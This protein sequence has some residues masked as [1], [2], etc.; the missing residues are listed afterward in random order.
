[1]V[2]PMNPTNDGGEENMNATPR[3]RSFPFAHSGLLAFALLTGLAPSAAQSADW[4]ITPSVTLGLG[5][6]DNINLATPGNEVSDRVLEI[7]P[8]IDA[9]YD[10][11]RFETDITYRLQALDYR[12]DSSLDETYHQLAGRATAWLVPDTFSLDALL[13]VRQQ[14]IDTTA[15]I[16]TSNIAGSGNLTDENTAYL[17]PRWTFRVSERAQADLRYATSKIDYD[18]A[19]LTDSTQEAIAA[20]VESTSQPSHLY[21]AAK[22]RQ[23]RIDFDS[24]EEI[25]FEQGTLE[26]GIPV[27]ARSRFIVLVGD[28]KNTFRLSDGSDAPDDSYWMV[29]LRSQHAERYQ[30]EILA[31]ERV[32]GNTAS[33]R[34][35]QQGRRWTTEALYTEDYITYAE[36]RLEI[37]PQAPE[38]ILPGPGLGAV[39]PEVYLRERAQ[40]GATLERPKTTFRVSVYDEDRS[41]QTSN[42]RESLKGME[43]SIIWR[44]GS[45]TTFTLS[46]GRQENQ[47]AGTNATDELKRVNLGVERRFGRRVQGNFYLRRADQSSDVSAREYVENSATL[48]A[49]LTF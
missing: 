8:G 25:R 44:A 7:T 33:L 19:S 11:P 14:V 12:D 2:R 24:Q 26:V 39:A 47:L 45:L 35:M 4:R 21:W 41:Y 28:E 31:G 9:S 20:V 13:S 18:D 3:F 48:S 6:S 32:F 46:G 29:G 27:F 40:I 36:T 38:S 30:L 43:L 42:N 16:P 34:W 37:D 10:G 15:P 23:S 5:H 17:S 22:Y 49:T 1:M